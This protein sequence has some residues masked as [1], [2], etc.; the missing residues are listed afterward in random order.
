MSAAA[1]ATSATLSAA[2]GVGYFGQSL[3]KHS[4]QMMSLERSTT[5]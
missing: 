5:I 2:T 4:G 1:S 3:W